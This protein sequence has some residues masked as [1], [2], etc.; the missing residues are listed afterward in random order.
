MNEDER[1]SYIRHPVDVPVQIYPQ[2]HTA[3]SHVQM[4]DVGKG[5]IALRSNMPLDAGV[6]LRIAIPHVHPPFEESCVVCWCQAEGDGFEVGI[7][8]LEPESMFKARMVEQVCYIEDYRRQENSKGRQLSAEEAA[9][10]WIS[11]Y[12][13]DFGLN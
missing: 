7:R 8:F 4:S 5:G 9:C 1:R 2:S 10:E 11:K 3:S 12:A 13:A 6:L